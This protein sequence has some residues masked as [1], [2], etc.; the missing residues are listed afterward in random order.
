MG[1]GGN[2]GGGG[3]GGGG[4][5]T[6]TPATGSRTFSFSTSGVTVNGMMNGSLTLADGGA[7]P[8]W[9]FSPGFNADRQWAGPIIEVVEGETA[10]ITLSSGRPHTIHLHGL[11]VDQ[12]NDGVPATSGYVSRARNNAGNFGRV[13]GKTKLGGTYTY[14][15]VAPHAGTYQYHCHVDTVLHYDMGMH[16]T[17][18]VRPK[19][20]NI[21]EAWDGGPTFAKEYVWQLGTFDT[22]WHN[23]MVSGTQTARYRPDRFM[24]NGRN[25]ADTQTDTTVA[26]EA[27]AGEKVLI[28]L[29]QT[30]YQSAE[31]SLGGLS[32]DVIASDGRPMQT[33]QTKTS[34]YMAPGERYDLLVTMPT[35]GTTKY[36]TINYYDNRGDSVIGSCV[37]TIKSV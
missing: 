11:D 12:A 24:I 13:E 34:I 4:G 19:S 25:G 30:S 20:G 15:F 1:R 17:I 22:S 21:T 35:A 10:N 14:S 36:A 37:T 18:I 33:Q 9:F 5:T 32:F 8:T 3:G 26:V 27:N 16:G 29:N 7:T 6:T 28:R 23:L 2:G 31:V